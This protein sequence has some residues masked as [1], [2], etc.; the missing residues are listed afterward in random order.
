MQD[1][2]YR[3]K[4]KRRNTPP[5]ESK[6]VNVYFNI[7]M[8]CARKLKAVYSLSLINQTANKGVC[9]MC[10]QPSSLDRYRKNN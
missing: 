3:R 9:P 10:W 8:D 5:P 2:E 1:F 4:R 7:C 6:P